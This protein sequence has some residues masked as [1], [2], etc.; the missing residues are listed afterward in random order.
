MIG[1]AI[2]AEELAAD[3]DGNNMIKQMHTVSATEPAWGTQCQSRGCACL[4]A[5]AVFQVYL[6]KSFAAAAGLIGFREN[7]AR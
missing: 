3:F 7:L 1:N 2:E 5:K 4:L 6:A